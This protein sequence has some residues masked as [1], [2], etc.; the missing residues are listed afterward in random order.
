MHIPDLA[1]D[2]QGNLRVVSITYDENLSE[3]ATTE[4]NQA[5]LGSGCSLFHQVI[6]NRAVWG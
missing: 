1:P 3:K 2:A 4:G 5:G 6:T